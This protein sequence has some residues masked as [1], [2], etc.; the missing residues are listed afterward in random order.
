MTPR[1]RREIYL[2]DNGICQLCQR[3]VPI[4]SFELDHVVPRVAGGPTT[5][6]NLQLA[7]AECNRLAGAKGFVVEYPDPP[8]AA[9]PL[10]DA[11]QRERDLDEVAA[12]LANLLYSYWKQH[13]HAVPQKGQENEYLATC[14]VCRERAPQPRRGRGT[15]SGG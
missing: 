10:T 7:H 3:P 2:R 8:P 11:E 1:L 14:A 15:I 13:H 5:L 12:A 6:D 4:E 9:R